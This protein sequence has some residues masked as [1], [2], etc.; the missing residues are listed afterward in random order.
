MD[1]KFREAKRN[2]RKLID[3]CRDAIKKLTNNL[4]ILFDS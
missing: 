2:K 3:P 4:A 1:A